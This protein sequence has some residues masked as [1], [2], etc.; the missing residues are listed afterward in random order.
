MPYD[1][2]TAEAVRSIRRLKLIRESAD[3]IVWITHD[4]EDWA[5]FPHAPFCFE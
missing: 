2:D 1:A 4:P 3:A 5:E